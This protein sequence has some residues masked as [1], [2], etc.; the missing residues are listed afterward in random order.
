M[1][2]ISKS[3][4]S[5]ILLMLI[6]SS[7]C[8]VSRQTVYPEFIAKKPNLGGITIL[9]DCMLIQGQRGDTNK[10]DIPENKQLAVDL[11]NQC[12]QRL[13]DKGYIIDRTMLT[14]IGLL[15]NQ[16]RSYRVVFSTDD[17]T[18]DDGNL[19]IATPPFY[20]D[21]SLVANGN[22]QSALAAL[23]MTILEAGQKTDTS[24]T[25]IPPATIVGSA[26]GAKTIIV[27]MAG[28]INIPI[29][30]VV[31][32]WTKNPNRNE[33]MIAVDPISNASMILY[34]IDG[35]SGEVLWESRA[36]E[37]GGTIHHDKITDMLTELLEELP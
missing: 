14:S 20:L 2:L 5:F 11:L 31:S 16:Q 24:K 3:L 35:S 4:A 32:E 34:I 19:P 27:L 15:M 6:L 37:K 22:F 9:T 25:I 21:K 7:G 8:S 10:I 28:G 29:T 36:H 26:I 18:I 12:S 1:S 23:Y 33:L 17:R 13:R 30:K